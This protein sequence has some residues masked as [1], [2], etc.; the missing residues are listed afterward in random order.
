MSEAISDIPIVTG[1]TTEKSD[2]LKLERV[3]GTVLVVE[4]DPSNRELLVEM[5]SMWGYEPLPVGSAEE[6]E[7]AT[8]RKLVGAA[9]VD[10]FLPGK[11]GTNLI[12]KL[13]ERFPDIMVI[14]MS[15]LGDAAMA[16]KCKGVGADLFIHKPVRADQLADALKSK[17]QSWH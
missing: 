6:A 8:R 5:L 3:K 14:G 9:I 10:V 2:D 12:P 16:R 7:F 17:H 4:D 15:A 13:R 1:H 11:S